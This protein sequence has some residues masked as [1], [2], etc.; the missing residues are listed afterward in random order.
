MGQGRWVFGAETGVL[1]SQNATTDEDEAFPGLRDRPRTAQVD[2]RV[3]C[4]TTSGVE[5][6]AGFLVADLSTRTVYLDE[7]VTLPL[8]RFCTI[9]NYSTSKV[10]IKVA[11]RFPTGQEVDPPSDTPRHFCC[12]NGARP[13]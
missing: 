3:N 11:N 7:S 12:A 9:H 5:A 2:P 4:Q 10:D 8:D 1:V 13:R 6:S